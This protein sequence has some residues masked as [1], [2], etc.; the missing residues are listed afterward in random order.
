MRRWKL[1]GN[2]GPGLAQLLSSIIICPYFVL[3]P[4]CP[5]KLAFERCF[6]A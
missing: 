3:I 5:V 2:R 4:Q 6:R 1:G